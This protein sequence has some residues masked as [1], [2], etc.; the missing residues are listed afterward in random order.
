MPPRGSKRPVES[1]ADAV[2]AK[3]DPSS[4]GPPVKKQKH[5]GRWH[6][7]SRPADGV[8]ATSL[9]RKQAINL[10]PELSPAQSP[11]NAPMR[12]PVFAAVR[13]PVLAPALPPAAVVATP[14][15]AEVSRRAVL[16][17]EN[18]QLRAELDRLKVQAENA[19]LRA[20]LDKL[21]AAA[22]VPVATH[23]AF[24]PPEPPAVQVSPI[25]APARQQVSPQF[26]PQFS[27]RLPRH[28]STG[29]AAA[30]IAAAAAAD[31]AAAASLASADAG[32][33]QA[34]EE[35]DLFGGDDA[36]EGAPGQRAT[37][38]QSRGRSGRGGRGSRSGKGGRRSSKGGASGR[39]GSGGR[40]ASRGGGK[41]TAGVETEPEPAAAVAPA[42]SPTPKPRTA[43]KRVIVPKIRVGEVFG[44][45]P[46]G[47]PQ[48]RPKAPRTAARAELSTEDAGMSDEDEIAAATADISQPGAINSRDLADVPV[49]VLIRRL[50]GDG[51]LN[52]EDDS[53]LF[54]AG[55]TPGDSAASVG[56]AAVATPVGDE[57]AAAGEVADSF[58]SGRGGGRGTGKR[59]IARSGKAAASEVAPG[60]GDPH[61]D[62]EL[63]SEEDVNS[64]S[65]AGDHSET[66]LGIEEAGA[67]VW[68][69]VESIPR[70]DVWPCAGGGGGRG[71]SLLSPGDAG[72]N[73]YAAGCLARAELN[74]LPTV[75]A[76]KGGAD[77]KG[78]GGE[79]AGGEDDEDAAEAEG[80]DGICGGGPFAGFGLL[81][82]QESVA[83]LLDPSS[84]VQR[85]LLDHAPGMGKT[86][87]M[88][89][90]LDN[91]FDD[92]R[93]KLAL[94]PNRESMDFF[95]LELLK[96]PSRWRRFFAQCKQAEAT[97][98]SGQT[99]FDR[100]RMQV[101]DLNNEKLK[102]SAKRRGVPVAKVLRE[103]LDAVQVSLDM[104][105]LLA[106]SGMLLP[107][108]VKA[109]KTEN[110]NVPVPRAPLRL[111]LHTTAGGGASQL[112]AKG[113][114]RSAIL[115]VG[116]EQNDPNP[117][118]GK[119]ILVDAI[120]TLARPSQRFKAQLAKLRF[121]L[122]NAQGSVLAA[123]TGHL[124]SGDS[125][126][127]RRLLDVIKGAEA[128]DGSDEGFV[129]FFGTRSAC[130]APCYG[131]P[132]ELG[133]GAAPG[134]F[135]DGDFVGREGHLLNS[136]FLRRHSL[137]GEALKR[138]ILKEFE[139]QTSPQFTSL[140]QEQRVAKMAPFCSL[141]IHH[142][143][144]HGANRNAILKDP[145]TYAPKMHAVA[146]SVAK[147]S[148]KA[149]VMLS[150]E[151]GLKV[152]VDIMQRVGKKAGF[153]VA[154][155]DE[156][157]S[158]NDAQKNLR[159][160]RYRVLIIDPSQVFQGSGFRHV[161]RVHVMGFPPRHGDLLR[162]IAPCFRFG[163]HSDLPE[164]ERTM[165]LEMHVVQMPKLLQQGC[166]AL[167]YRQLI[168][169]AS[170]LTMSLM[171][172]GTDMENATEA[173]FKLLKK[174][175]VRSLA[176]L[177]RE[178]QAEDGQQFIDLITET[179]LEK[180][181]SGT[182]QPTRSLGL[183][184]RRL[185]QGL[186]NA[187][188]L[189]RALVAAAKTAEETLLARA[190]EAFAEVQGNLQ[191]LRGAA[192]DRRLLAGLGELPAVSPS[193]AASAQ[194]TAK[195]GPVAAAGEGEEA[196]ADGDE[197]DAPEDEAMENAL[198][199]ECDEEGQAD[200][201]PEDD[202]DID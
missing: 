26:A 49:A 3:V 46:V 202:S 184:L 136:D 24:P 182:Q 118:S 165:A 56:S 139:L 95:L 112:D 75:Q 55:C 191:E 98:A 193:T 86:L 116:S 61:L 187:D 149:V 146:K 185:R 157:G 115:K 158:F 173:C 129:S 14:V 63:E 70:P 138:Y 93:P 27:P 87:V 120:H 99:Y 124:A 169:S 159:G 97:L 12:S 123:F 7:L 32:E 109:F 199:D 186:D 79:A 53:A 127:L 171:S 143:R 107:S 110:P 60:S 22:T 58:A 197:A 166:T 152:M 20:Q 194:A 113:R 4:G 83:F 161:R 101:W 41:G 80:E 45:E 133:P 84:P 33:V 67:D 69:S 43:S 57:E 94:F 54:A 121:H 88:L 144:L 192:V 71:K 19:E 131:L 73:A 174:R 145:K 108:R 153:K 137:H 38:G 50:T 200:A 122:Y 111:M 40:G 34:Q 189:E 77:V 35:A 180:L 100:K 172:S 103:L 29:A 90:L 11:L 39:D 96:W 130:A 167:I 176:D 2:P 183:A 126:Q 104:K 52:S 134:V 81:P 201:Q 51:K 30:A 178:V 181:G 72:F 141:F 102:Q 170:V 5:P 66:E 25:L 156:L 74:V 105:M 68:K 179:A 117:F 119:V 42:P 164:E 142:Q 188:L 92:P 9:E 195:A 76:P 150:R 15:K 44:W 78:R 13:S 82:H 59:S 65:E 47:R 147:T 135:L 132:R 160:E 85:L 21:R 190:R 163:C 16:E 125:T 36:S 140:P 175:N 17:A 177:Q 128:V 196:A 18:A 148:E 89:R 64:Q 28:G 1:P 10:S 8:V 31:A 6:E 155:I 37:G 48:P 162:W 23:T 91:F 106:K 198:F 151:M 168:L 114:P 154:T 62:E